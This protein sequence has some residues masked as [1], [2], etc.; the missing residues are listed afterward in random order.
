MCGFE[1]VCLFVCVLECFHVHMQMWAYSVCTNANKM[2]CS[3]SDKSVFK[4]VTLS[5]VKRSKLSN[6]L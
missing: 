1:C 5:E 4:N 2:H 6:V 3:V